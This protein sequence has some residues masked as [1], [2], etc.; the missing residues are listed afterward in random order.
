MLATVKQG[1]GL[2]TDRERSKRDVQNCSV[3]E[4]SRLREDTKCQR[5]PTSFQTLLNFS[6]RKP[7]F[8]GEFVVPC[9]KTTSYVSKAS[10]SMPG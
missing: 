4:V 3:P 7:T 9:S 5:T 8:L 6:D 1:L 2:S 10:E